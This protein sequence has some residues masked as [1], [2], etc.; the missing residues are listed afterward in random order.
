MFSTAADRSGARP[1]DGQAVNGDIYVFTA[2]DSGV[3]TSYSSRVT[4]Y[5]DDPAMA[6]RARWAERAA[7]YDFAG[8]GIATAA[9]FDTGSLASGSH[10]ITARIP[11]ASGGA[12]VIHA[13]FTTGVADI[14]Q[15]PQIAPL[16]AVSL[17]EQASLDIVVSASDPD[18]DAI[19]L[20]ALD[21][22]SFAQFEDNGDGTAALIL[23]PLAGD[24]G[25]YSISIEASDGALSDVAALA[26]T[27]MPSIGAPQFVVHP[28][29]RTVSEGMPAE[30]SA[31]AAGTT[32]LAYKWQRNG[33]D[34][35]G[36]F[37]QNLVTEPVDRADDGARIRAVVTN[38]DGSVVSNEAKLFV[39]PA[40]QVTVDPDYPAWLQHADG[41]PFFLCAPGEPEDFL[42]RGARNADGTRRG[43]QNAIIDK[44]AGTG[45]NGLYMQIVRSHGGDGAQ[46]HNPFVNGDPA[47]GLDQDIL[48]QWEDWFTRMNQAGIQIYLFFYDDSATIWGGGDTVPSAERAFLQAIVQR[49][50]HHANLVWVIAEEYSEAFTA[51]RVANM[52]AVIRNADS[53]RHPIAVHKLDGL[54]FSE[55]AN[56]PNIDQFAIQYNVSAPQT[57]HEGMVQAFS[58]AR[59]RYSLNLSESLGGGLGTNGRLKNWAA[60]MGGAY[61]MVFEWD[62]VGTS[63]SDLAGCGQ[64]VRFMEGTNFNRMTPR[65]DLAAGATQYVLSDGSGSAILYAASANG[66]M[67]LRNQPAGTYD[68]R[69]LDIASGQSVE[70]SGLSVGGGTV[71]WPRPNGIGR[72]L[73]VWVRPASGNPANRPPVATVTASPN[74][75]VAPLATSLDG[76]ASSDPDGGSLSYAWDFGDGTT[77][78]G[79][80]VQHTY[81]QAGSYHAVLTVSDPAGAKDSAAVT[82]VV[83][84]GSGGGDP[85]S[86]YTLLVSDSPD[87]SNARPLDGQSLSGVAYIF[88][89]PDQGVSTNDSNRVLFYLNDP[90]QASAPIRGERSA[91]FDFAGGGVAWAAPLNVREMAP[92]AHTVTAS[93]PLAD[94]TR[95]VIHATFVAKP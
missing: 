29:D 45:A 51:Q 27:V 95:K 60:A 62:V 79:A 88:T 12:T 56:D 44:L 74:A 40:S 85:G 3:Q 57:V 54:S 36:A 11:L 43:D 66:S 15:P 84:Q 49:F 34:I 37:G 41:R 8:G 24:D 50:Q 32:P 5:L 82:I 6:G 25:A 67:G 58:E 83:Q 33:Q 55:F 86:G 93:L 52:A 68:L 73:A 20:L 64:L 17:A 19:S 38:T 14:N 13:S 70:Q 10:S 69:W 4:F 89:G 46:D 28:T 16:E 39:R 72:E 59:G 9:P 77:G 94:G 81:A 90:N 7:P 26:V 87:R 65:D 30:F 80:M 63:E 2:P 92:G 61:S 53:Q 21:L 78:S 1:L 71:S 76:R 91:P 35:D 22:P 75:G 18:G 31:A 48:A 23:A 42:Y 47:R